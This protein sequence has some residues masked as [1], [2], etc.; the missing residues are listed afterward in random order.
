MRVFSGQVGSMTVKYRLSSVCA[1]DF[2]WHWPAF[3]IQ[4][5]IA[6]FF[7]EKACLPEG[8]A[9]LNGSVIIS[10]LLSSFF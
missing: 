4:S 9:N 8:V 6:K 1:L 3:L 2:V 10:Q 7:R 5:F